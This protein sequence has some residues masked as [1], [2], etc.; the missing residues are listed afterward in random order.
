MSADTWAFIDEYGNPNLEV[1]KPGVSKFY[2]VVA[3]L[4]PE[5]ALYAVRRALERA[6]KLAMSCEPGFVLHLLRWT[7]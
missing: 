2:I 5:P 6:V 7:G 3:V 4:L 1:E